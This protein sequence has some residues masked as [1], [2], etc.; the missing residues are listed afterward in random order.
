MKKSA[1][2][3]YLFHEKRRPGGRKSPIE[4]RWEDAATTDISDR[5]IYYMFNPFGPHTMNQVVTNIEKS[6]RM[7]PRKVTIIYVNPVHRSL[8]IPLPA[9]FAPCL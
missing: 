3:L 5:T 8:R 2:D 6:L 7:N 9:L 4:V 1:A